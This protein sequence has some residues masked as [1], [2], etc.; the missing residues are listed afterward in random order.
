MS[1][2]EPDADISRASTQSPPEPERVPRVHITIERDTVVL[3]LQA[4]E[5]AAIDAAEALRLAEVCL[6]EA[7]TAVRKAQ[8]DSDSAA[9]RAT[10]VRSKV[11][12]AI[13]E[14]GA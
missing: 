9:T 12:H 2:T 10:F 6:S 3:V 1:L 11:E 14:S 7:Q 5:S 8:L 4:T 13:G